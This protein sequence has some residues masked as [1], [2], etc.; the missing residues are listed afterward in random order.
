MV[1]ILSNSFCSS[2]SCSFINR[3]F[4]S[5]YFNE[6][7][8]KVILAREDETGEDEIR[9]DEAREAGVR[10]AGARAGNN[11]IEYAKKGHQGIR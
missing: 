1:V 10:E 11:L 6:G 7:S 5:V 3:V 9:E 2:L 4:A 8:E